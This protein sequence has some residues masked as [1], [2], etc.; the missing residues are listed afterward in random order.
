MIIRK[1]KLFLYFVGITLM[2]YIT[3]LFI[4]GAYA[5][6]H[7]SL[8]LLLVS[9]FDI[10][11]IYEIKAEL[12][13]WLILIGFCLLSILWSYDVAETLVTIKRE[14]VY[15]ILAFIMSYLVLYLK[16][17]KIF[18]MLGGLLGLLLLVSSSI[19]SYHGLFPE[20]AG[21]Y[22]GV[23]DAS[24]MAVL[25]LCG[26]VYALVF[27]GSPYK[28]TALV[29]V[30][31]SIA[32]LIMAQNRM[33]ILCIAIM[34]CFYLAILIF[35]MENKK[36]S[37]LVFM[38]L[39]LLVILSSLSIGLEKDGGI[40]II[41][42]IKSDSRIKDIW[43]FYTAHLMDKPFT[44]YGFGYLI[45]GKVLATSFPDYF[46]ANFRTHAH[47]V[48]INEIIQIGWIGLIIFLSLYSYLGYKFF[49]IAKNGN[50]LG[51][52][53]MALIVTFFAKS[54]T[55]DFFIRSNIIFFW[56]LMGM[57]LSL[58]HQQNAMAKNIS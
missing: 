31:T 33:S 1:N 3:S 52:L 43:P 9:V 14:L 12:Y 22:I 23:S 32:I 34:I 46:N 36:I 35:R 50:S 5:I 55:D 17:V 20:L 11:K 10:K 29:I 8:F 37:V 26:A 47:N 44:G 7:I 57:V 18:A 6:K 28:E 39:S 40:P 56:V 53:G 25:I 4:S 13:L 51:I 19:A 41:D 16:G 30:I 21:L 54:M 45:P 42:L 24:T 27:L 48:I 38:F 2:L 49:L 15:S 58:A